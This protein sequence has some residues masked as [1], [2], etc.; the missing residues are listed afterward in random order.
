MQGSNCSFS[1]DTT[2]LAALQHLAVGEGSKPDSNNGSWSDMQHA[3]G[4]KKV[5]SWLDLQAANEPR[6]VCS[7]CRR[8]LR[9]NTNTFMAFDMQFCS[10][11]CREDMMDVRASYKRRPY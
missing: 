7:S 1:S 2:S 10:E 8:Q 6:R 9:S 11:I 4:T 5:N 3:L